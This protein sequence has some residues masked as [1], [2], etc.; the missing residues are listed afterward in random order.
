MRFTLR[1]TI[2]ISFKH[3]ASYSSSEMCVCVLLER[4]DSPATLWV[5]V[6]LRHHAVSSD[7]HCKGCECIW[8]ITRQTRSSR[9]HH[10]I[11][12]VCFWYLAV[13]ELWSQMQRQLVARAIVVG[14]KCVA[15]HCV[16]ARG[17]SV[18]VCVLCLHLCEAHARTQRESPSRAHTTVNGRWLAGCRV[19]SALDARLLA[20]T[21]KTT[22]LETQ[23]NFNFACNSF[24][25]SV[26]HWFYYNIIIL[27]YWK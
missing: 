8:Q 13:I 18:C 2:Q 1:I 7:I 4:F 22:T 5:C 21:H 23:T 17:R 19:H 10:I 24:S 27:Y 12:S 11:L 15:L 14:W 9:K 25:L 3:C 20:H 16:F 6:C 26:W